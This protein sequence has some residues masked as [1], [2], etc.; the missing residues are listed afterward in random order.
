MNNEQIEMA[1]KQFFS[2]F[3]IDPATGILSTHPNKRF[4][5]LPYIGSQYFSAAKKI[6]FV[7]L[8]IGIDEM[9]VYHNKDRYQN[10]DE[11]REA[12]EQDTKNF[13][14]HIAGT[15]CSAL[16]LLKEVFGW[17]D[18]WA[19]FVSFDNFRQAATVKHRKDNENPLSYVALTNRYKFVEVGRD[20][21]HGDSDRVF[22][23][24]ELEEAFLLKEIELLKP[25]IVLFQG[26][27]FTPSDETIQEIKRS[28]IEV[29]RAY[30][31]SYFQKTGIQNP[32]NYVDA[33]ERV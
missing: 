28:N 9:Y 29:I 27:R 8:D 7:G 15:Y 21:S 25:N 17:E 3:G 24:R 11:R 20:K 31:P 13:N 2:D 6:L 18:A 12:I 32:Q 5:T 33:F 19:K 26:E 30:H 14:Q 22:V 4:A 23:D 10:L 16:F 1:Y